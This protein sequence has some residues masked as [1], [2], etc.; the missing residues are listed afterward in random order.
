LEWLRYEPKSDVRFL[1][2]SPDGH[3]RSQR[4]AAMQPMPGGA[5][6]MRRSGRSWMTS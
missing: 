3:A 4:P 5:C 6:H 2:L 1:L